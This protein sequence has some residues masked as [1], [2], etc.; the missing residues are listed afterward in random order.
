MHWHA[1]YPPGLPGFAEYPAIPLWEFVRPSA[2]TAIIDG[3]E[4]VTYRELRT[5][6]ER[7]AGWFRKNGVRPD[8]RVLLR[9]PNSIAFVVAYYG[10][11]RAGGIV[12]AA[13]PELGASA[14]N[15]QR[16]DVDPLLVVEGDVGAAD[17]PD[18]HSAEMAA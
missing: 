3:D 7:A 13:G 9:L 16:S 4:S 11:L 18:P 10:A 1:F 8:E 12:S 15:H 6:I 17:P 2:K 14:W 5:R